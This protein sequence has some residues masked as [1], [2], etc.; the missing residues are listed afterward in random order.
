MVLD[1][2]DN[3]PRFNSTFLNLYISENEPSGTIVGEFIAV[4]SDQGLAA[5]LVF[6]VLGDNAA[7]LVIP[8]LCMH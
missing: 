2:N 1:I 4:D 3:P 5:S 8:W 6:M 7:R